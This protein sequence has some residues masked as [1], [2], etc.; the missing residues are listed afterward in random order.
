ML[1][2]YDG[3][4]L[5]WTGEGIGLREYSWCELQ[6]LLMSGKAVIKL[7]CFQMNG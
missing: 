1:D 4:K 5:P 7:Y 3:L 2:D 6:V